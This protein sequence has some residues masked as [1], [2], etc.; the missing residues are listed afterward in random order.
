MNEEGVAQSCTAAGGQ[1]CA[2]GQS[3]G[4][5]HVC[6]GD[7]CMLKDEACCETYR[8]GTRQ[9]CNLEAGTCVART[10]PLPGA[11]GRLGVSGG[12]LASTV[13]AALVVLLL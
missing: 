1:C 2:R 10:G 9:Q 12:V 7:G 3:C 13:G 5:G 6:C 11:A 4:V 8:C